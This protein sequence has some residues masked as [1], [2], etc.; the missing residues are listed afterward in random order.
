VFAS[1]STVQAALGGMGTACGT[2]VGRRWRIGSIEAKKNCE[3]SEQR[4]ADASNGPLLSWVLP[5]F[6]GDAKSCVLDGIVA[7]FGPLLPSQLLAPLLVFEIGV[8]SF[9]GPGGPFTYTE[10]VAK[11]GVAST[12]SYVIFTGFE[13]Q[14]FLSQVPLPEAAYDFLPTVESVDLAYGAILGVFCG[15]CGFVGFLLLA[16]GG[17]LGNKV[18]DLFD[19]L[20]GRL[21]MGGNTLPFLLT[22]T[23]GGALV[24]L[25][26]V[27]SPLILSDGAEQMGVLFTGA[28][29]LGVGTMVCCAALK[30]LAVGISLGF[31]F[32]GGQLFPF[33]F[34]G[35]CIGSTV[36]LIFPTIPL[37]VAFPAC[38]SAMAC[39][40]VPCFFT[41]TFLSSMSLV[42]GGAG[43][44]PVFVA[45]VLS[46]TT[47]CG[48]GL[49]QALLSMKR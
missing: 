4:D 48:L 39:A 20:G 2:L 46:Y 15:M 36:H 16:I 6:R 49:V 42:L 43:T 38:M 24:G 30:L 22:P 10:Q 27:A 5:D 17:V 25:L 21:G 1:I 7:A 23:V 9:F 3:N 19:H 37:L 31:G 8:N 45:C 32:V 41:F 35:A 11:A 14:T 12:I 13:K 47:V 18:F 40:F 44:A 33:I 29:A 34:S 28:G 26:A